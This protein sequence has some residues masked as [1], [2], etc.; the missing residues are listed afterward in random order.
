MTVSRIWNRWVQDGNTGT[1]CWI[2]MALITSSREDRHVIRMVFMDR[3]TTSLS[4]SQE[5]GRLLDNKCLH[6]QFDDVCSS[7]DSQHGD[8]G[9][10]YP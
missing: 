8:H 6:E 5:R 9:F 3:L 2:S 10:G 4:M 7:M 1:P